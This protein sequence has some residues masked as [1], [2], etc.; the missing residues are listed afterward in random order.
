[1]TACKPQPV[2]E[3]LKLLLAQFFHGLI[4]QHLCTHQAKDAVSKAKSVGELLQAQAL[5]LPLEYGLS[6]DFR[7][8]SWTSRLREMGEFS[9]PRFD[10]GIYFPGHFRIIKSDV[11]HS[12]VK[13]AQRSPQPRNPDWSSTLRQARSAPRPWQSH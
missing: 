6:L 4:D 3:A 12:A 2:L 13:I 9:I 1:M 5:L 10:F 11:I 8:A 7:C